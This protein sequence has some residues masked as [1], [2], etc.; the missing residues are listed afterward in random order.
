MSCLIIVNKS[1]YV[2]VTLRPIKS[3]PL[4]INNNQLNMFKK[5][6]NPESQRTDDTF[7]LPFIYSEKSNTKPAS[8]NDP[9]LTVKTLKLT[10]SLNFSKKNSSKI[11]HMKSNSEV[12]IKKKPNQSFTVQSFSY[13]HQS[14]L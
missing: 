3:T 8:Q 10:P 13:H 9:T 7:N 6:T 2:K 12:C 11:P 14:S 1:F 5:R 4:I